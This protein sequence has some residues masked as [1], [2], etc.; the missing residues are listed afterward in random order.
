MEFKTFLSAFLRV[1]CQI[2]RG[3]QRLVY[4]LLSW[5]EWQPVFFRLFEVLRC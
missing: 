2:I 4:R 1:P 5:N 3:G